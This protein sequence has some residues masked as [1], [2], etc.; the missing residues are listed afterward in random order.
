MNPLRW[1]PGRC[2]ACDLPTLSNNRD[3]C[4]ICYADLPWCEAVPESLTPAQRVIAPL[5]FQGGV[6]D[7]IHR[8]KYQ[9][10][11]V[12]GQVLGAVLADAIA[13][14][15]LPD[16]AQFGLPPPWQQPPTAIVP[17]PM[18][19]LNWVL[20]GHNPATV[21]ARPVAKRLRL[22]ILETLVHRAPKQQDQHSLSRA[23]RQQSMR[24]AFSVIAEPPAQVAIVDDVLTTGA[25]CQALSQALMEAGCAEVHIW[26]S[27]YTPPLGS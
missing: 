26:C 16:V 22:P 7:W 9:R 12:E 2:L 11:W 1:L 18:P 27:A 23:E 4:S 13:A 15:Y 3:L 24:N 10:G 8:L 6:R 21:L 17:V 25:T 5:Y 20:R 14:S 19:P